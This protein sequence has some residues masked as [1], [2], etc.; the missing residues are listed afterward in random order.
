VAAE[1]G[2]ER[3]RVAGIK[4][5]VRAGAVRMSFHLHNTEADVD[6]VARA[7]GR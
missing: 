5:S 1:G 2:L 4:A 3:L 6:A 7:L